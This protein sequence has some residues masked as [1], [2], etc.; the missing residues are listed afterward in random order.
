MN[1]MDGISGIIA[2]TMATAFAAVA[3][4]GSMVSLELVAKIAIPIG[5]M[6]WWMSSKFTRI[7][8]HQTAV[9]NRLDSV[10]TR[11]DRIETVLKNCPAGKLS[12]CS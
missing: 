9:N 6:V 12:D 3:L 11:L 8:D 10:V 5:G 1:M 7:D 2:G 4:D